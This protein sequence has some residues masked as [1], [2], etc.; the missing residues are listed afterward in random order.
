MPGENAIFLHKNERH[1]ALV[2]CAGA[3][4]VF[5]G[6]HR[7]ADYRP[8]GTIVQTTEQARSPR[9][10]GHVRRRRGREM[11]AP[12]LD[13]PSIGV[14]YSHEEKV[15]RYRRDNRPIWTVDIAHGK[16]S[17]NY[18]DIAFDEADPVVGERGLRPVV[19]GL[20][21]LGTEVLHHCNPPLQKVTLRRHEGS[22][23]GEY[24]C[25][26]LGILLNESVSKGVSERANGCFVS[27]LAG[28][29]R[30]GR[31]DDERTREKR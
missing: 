18:R 19:D 26:E 9:G 10:L 2:D 14:A 15:D 28:T 7:L 17:I 25:S 16:Q 3:I 6:P 29:R 27:S 8:D 1:A 5:L 12:I 24:G 11:R 21:R 23:F 31:T 20:L 13:Q 4:A 30:A 22:I